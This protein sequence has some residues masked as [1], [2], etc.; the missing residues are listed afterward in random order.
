MEQK[1]KL[2]K[3]VLRKDVVS[4]LGNEE[5]HHLRGGTDY[6][7]SG[8]NTCYGAHT[9]P[10]HGTYPILSQNGYMCPLQTEINDCPNHSQVGSGCDEETCG[11]AYT[12][13]G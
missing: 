4:R 6:L 9:C 10:T 13:N 2:K 8:W 7:C 12:C 1:K 3:L 5:M 11:W